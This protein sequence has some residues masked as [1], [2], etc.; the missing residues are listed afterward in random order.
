MHRCAV[1]IK[2][3]YYCQLVEEYNYQ[4]LVALL[5][6][7]KCSGQYCRWEREGGNVLVQST[8]HTP[9]IPWLCFIKKDDFFIVMFSV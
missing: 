8:A 9:T 1:H 5:E 4:I 7:L 2:Q 6:V 3:F